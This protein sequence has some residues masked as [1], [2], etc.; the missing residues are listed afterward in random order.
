MKDEDTYNCTYT[1]TNRDAYSHSHK[2]YAVVSGYK[3]C[4]T[5][6][7]P[8][9]C[10]PPGSSIHVI[11][12]ARILEWVAISFSTGSSPPS[13]GTHVSFTGGEILYR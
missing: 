10:S 6:C 5:L 7:D 1:Y 8:M 9:N 3:S 12:Q 4:L 11:S 2:Q 13:N